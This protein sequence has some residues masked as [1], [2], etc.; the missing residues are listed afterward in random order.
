[1]GTLLEK[2]GFRQLIEE[3]LKPELC[4]TVDLVEVA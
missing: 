1:V 2:L 3:T 4:T